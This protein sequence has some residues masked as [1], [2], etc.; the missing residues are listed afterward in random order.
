MIRQNCQNKYQQPGGGTAFIITLDYGEKPRDQPPP[1]PTMRSVFEDVRFQDI[2]VQGAKQAG[3]IQGF[4]RNLLKGLSFYNA[5]PSEQTK[6][7]LGLPCRK[8]F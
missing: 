2:V 3:L 7:W 4:P 5:R 8:G 6:T 1:C